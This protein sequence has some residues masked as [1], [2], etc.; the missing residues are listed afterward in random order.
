VEGS[1]ETGSL[2]LITNYKLRMTVRG[3]LWCK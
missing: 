1:W 3:G 2:F